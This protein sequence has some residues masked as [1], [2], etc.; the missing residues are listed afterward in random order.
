MLAL[1]ILILITSFAF[2]EFVAWSTHKYIMHGFLWNLHRDHHRKEH[3][4]P[5]ERNDLFFLMFAIP[6]IL[7]MYFGYANGW[8]DPR[9]WIGLGITLY[10]IAYVFAHDVFIHQRIR[11]FTRSD[12]AYLRAMRKAH[13][14]HHKHLGKEDGECF[15]FLWVPSKYLD[16]AK[17]PRAKK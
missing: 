6:G 3:D 4:H 5:M 15:G 8:M 11:I 13:K 7:F 12:N 17:R 1:N 9:L 14:I 16:E 2:M 10:G